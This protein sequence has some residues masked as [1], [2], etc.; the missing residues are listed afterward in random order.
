LGSESRNVI[1]R[2]EFTRH[3]AI[4]AAVTFV[5]SRGLSESPVREQPPLQQPT[6]A[7]KLSS[8]GQSEADARYQTIMALYASRFSDAQKADLQRLNLAAQTVLGRLRANQLA[9]S[10]SPALYLKPLIER[11]K[12]SAA[13]APAPPAAMTKP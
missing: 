8:E 1:S 12:K 3:A 13:A 9:N 2:R 11:E 5:P 10:D 7:P 4:S 6:G